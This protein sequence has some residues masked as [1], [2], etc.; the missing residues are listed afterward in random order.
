MDC[1]EVVRMMELFEPKS[2]IQDELDLL[3]NFRN[4]HVSIH[5]WM[6]NTILWGVR[7]LGTR[8]LDT[9]HCNR[10][11]DYIQWSGTLHKKHIRKF[12]IQT[13]PH[14]LATSRLPHILA[15]SSSLTSVT[16]ITGGTNHI[17]RILG[18]NCPSLKLLD[19]TLSIE[20]TDAGLAG[21]LL[22]QWRSHTLHPFRKMTIA[23][24]RAFSQ[25]EKNPCSAS[26]VKV[27]LVGT[28]VTLR[29]TDLACIIL[30]R[31]SYYVGFHPDS[32]ITRPL[33]GKTVGV[34]R[35]SV[36]LSSADSLLPIFG[37]DENEG[38]RKRMRYIVKTC[39]ERFEGRGHGSDIMDHHF[40]PDWGY[41]QSFIRG[42]DTHLIEAMIGTRLHGTSF[43][44]TG[45][46]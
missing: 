12:A 41:G 25:E 7:A 26:L 38:V 2:V 28:S 37:G 45:W 44:I 36:N 18:R 15:Q 29:A 24:A 42:K 14:A 20:V 21:L 9:E 16:V 10:L 3:G 39:A 33:G 17:L 34:E 35:S 32:I 4:V 22:K 11:Y 1:T 27:I 13:E 31:G 43:H 19:V 23:S 40:V 30:G 5:H 6:N 8:D 46:F